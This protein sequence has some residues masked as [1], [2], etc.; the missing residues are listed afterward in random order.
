MS[1]SNCSSAS[2][3]AYTQPITGAVMQK[4]AVTG[5][6]ESAFKNKEIAPVPPVDAVAG[7]ASLS[8]GTLG[9]L[10]QFQSE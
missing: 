6:A 4:N 3:S 1:I 9:A 10:L 2:A 5:V 8:A 7:V